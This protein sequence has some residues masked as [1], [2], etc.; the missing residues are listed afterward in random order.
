VLYCES[1]DTLFTPD[2]DEPAKFLVFMPMVA[3]NR[4]GELEGRLAESWEHSSDFRTWTIRLR[5]GI[6]WHDGVPVTAH[7][8]KFTLDLM[9]HPDT[10]LAPSNYSVK[11]LDHRTYSVTYD[12]QYLFD[13]GVLSDYFACWPKHLL[14][15]LDPKQINT[16]DFW[17][18]PV[19][20][21]PYRH[22]RTVPD[23]M[24][25]FEANR[26]YAFGKPKIENVI[27]KFGGPSAMP[28][29]LGGDVDAAV[30]AR[31]SDVSNISRYNHFRVHQN[32]FGA[33]LALYWNI[34]HPFFRDPVVRRALTYAVNRRELLDVLNLPADAH[35]VDFV[36][37]DGQG[38][39]GDFRPPTPHDPELARQL[40]D[41]A[42]CRLNRQG[43]R[44]HGGRPF[45]FKVLV[46]SHVIGGMPSAVYVQDQLKRL[47]IHMEITIADESVVWPRIKSG[48]FEAAIAGRGAWALGKD[49][50]DIGYNNSSFFALLESTNA[51]FDPEEKE[52]LHGELTAIFQADLP[53]TFLHPLANTTIAS[54]RIRGLEDH[55]YRG[56]LT[57]WMDDLWLEEQV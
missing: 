46:A 1:D 35:P 7:D 49:L 18:R 38:R 12:R 27:L 30:I 47:G 19:G 37:T 15:K 31:R 6:H 23:T 36:R 2:R 22:V 14:E 26:D 28:E 21:G 5:N 29:L 48:A 55:P 51:A 25:E 43:L 20:S 50:H 8:V 40:L 57:Q 13:E 41:Q 53:L 32:C 56:D 39:R 3:W 9:Q 44:E 11:L 34:R 54:S 17:K 16:W 52:R 24:M 42:G 45:R 33:G 10:L 4:R